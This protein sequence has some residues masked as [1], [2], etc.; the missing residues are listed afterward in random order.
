MLA[1]AAS[2]RPRSAKSAPGLIIVGAAGFL[3]QHLLVLL[4]SADIA[5]LLHDLYAHPE[6]GTAPY[7]VLHSGPSATADIEGVLIRGAEGVRSLTVC[8]LPRQT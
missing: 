6:F 1:S 3:A 7:L 4:D 8:L 2:A 5:V